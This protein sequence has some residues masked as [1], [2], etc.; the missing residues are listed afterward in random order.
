MG[1]GRGKKMSNAGNNVYTRILMTLLIMAKN[2][3]QWYSTIEN[4]FST[5]PRAPR[6]QSLCS[7]SCSQPGFQQHRYNPGSPV[8]SALS[9]RWTSFWSSWCP[10][11][12]AALDHSKGFLILNFEKTSVSSRRHWGF[13]YANY[14]SPLPPNPA[15]KEEGQTWKGTRSFKSGSDW[16]HVFTSSVLSQNTATMMT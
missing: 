10:F 6:G 2:H 12:F 16:K 7:A 14:P 1:N 8:Q 9:S 5:S 4:W 13:S 11:S 15:S 3:M